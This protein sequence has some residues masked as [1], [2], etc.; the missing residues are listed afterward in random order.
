MWPR[1]HNPIESEL[2]AHVL[3]SVHVW[4]T[5][6]GCRPN[7]DFRRARSNTGLLNNLLA[8]V[9]PMQAVEHRSNTGSLWPSCCS[10][11]DPFQEGQAGKLVS[12]SLW[13][14]M[15]FWRERA[16]VFSVAE[17]REKM[18]EARPAPDSLVTCL[19][20]R[21][22][23]AADGRDSGATKESKRLRTSLSLTS[24][25]ASLEPHSQDQ[26]VIMNQWT[27]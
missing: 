22:L 16:L 3:C 6:L 4:K 20:I 25:G 7:Q 15:L 12:H 17:A 14:F 24:F 19:T 2:G 18:A 13:H 26:L 11:G 21:C 23:S 27:D 8:L 1:P 9:E 10:V 5:G